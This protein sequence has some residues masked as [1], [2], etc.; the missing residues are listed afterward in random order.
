MY[1]PFFGE[2]MGTLV[3]ISLGDGAVANFLLK[4]SKGENSGGMVITTAWGMA[5]VAGIFTAIAFGSPG[6]HIKPAITLTGAVLSGDWS[7]VGLFWAAQV[8]GGFASAS[9]VWLVYVHH[10]KVTPDPEAKLAVFCTHPP[11]SAFPPTCSP[12]L[13]PPPASSLLASVSGAWPCQPPAFRLVWARG[14]G[15]F[16]CG[17]SAWVSADQ[18]D[19][20]STPPVTLARASLT[21][22]FTVRTMVSPV[23]TCV[24]CGEDSDSFIHKRNRQA[25]TP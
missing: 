22:C 23:F 2:F 4:K 9:L 16:W 15:E 18:P 5:V 3:L 14:C 8:L 6:A 17:A 21:L 20:R 11:S 12:K 24:P 25:R 19:T 1:G 13:L 10:R 7:N